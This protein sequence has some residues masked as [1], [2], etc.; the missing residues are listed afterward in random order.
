MKKEK[1]ADGSI[2]YWQ[3]GVENPWTVPADMVARI[4]E[5]ALDK[6]F[7]YTPSPYSHPSEYAHLYEA[8]A[9]EED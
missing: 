6:K 7:S 2:K 5:S 4:G 8:R 1:Q 3:D 9:H